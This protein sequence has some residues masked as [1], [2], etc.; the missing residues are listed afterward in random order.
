MRLSLFPI[1]FVITQ[2]RTWTRE[3]VRGYIGVVGINLDIYIYIYPTAI[4]VV[5]PLYHHSHLKACL[6]RLGKSVVKDSDTRFYSVAVSDGGLWMKNTR[7]ERKPGYID[8]RRKT[9]HQR[10]RI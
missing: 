5:A 2:A 9:D 6:I 10:D 7:K 8:M 1:I 4:R 3:Y